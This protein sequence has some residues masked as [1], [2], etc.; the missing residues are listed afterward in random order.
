M[1]VYF[2]LC[3]QAEALKVGVSKDVAKRLASIAT[4]NPEKIHLLGTIQCGGETEARSIERLFLQTWINKSMSGEWIR[5]DD[6]VRESVQKFIARQ[7]PELP[8][9]GRKFLAPSQLAEALGVHERTVRRWVIA[10][11][12]EHRKSPGGRWMIPER[13]VE[14]ILAERRKPEAAPT[15]LAAPQPAKKNIFGPRVEDENQ[16]LEPIPEI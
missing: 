15:K 5:W 9:S 12:I 8:R 16:T 3:K 7:F 2:M 11:K 14:E 10:G 1:F 4:S 13:V 6:D